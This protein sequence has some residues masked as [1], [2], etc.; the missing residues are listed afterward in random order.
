MIEPL[1]DPVVTQKHQSMEPIVVHHW[2]AIQQ[3]RARAL[4]AKYGLTLEPGE[5]RSPGDLTVQRVIKPIR[6]RVHR[7]CHRCE[8]SFGRDKICASCQHVR[9]KKCPRYP[10][11]SSTESVAAGAAGPAGAELVQSLKKKKKTPLQPPQP[12]SHPVLTIPSRTGGQDLILK[13]VR[14]RVRRT[15][16][17]CATVFLAHSKQCEKCQHIRCRKCPRDPYVHLPLAQFSH[18]FVPNN[19]NFFSSVPTST[20]T[21]TATPET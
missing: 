20:N 14:Q 3:E 5:W 15:C 2:S 17:L 1:Q 16:H 18:G 21:P 9:C 7:T 6:V 8:T 12:P 19:A 13:P 10:T 11:P 4:F